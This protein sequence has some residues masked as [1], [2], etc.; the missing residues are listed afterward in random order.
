MNG[1]LVDKNGGRLAAVVTLLPVSLT[2]RCLS[3]FCFNVLHD[4]VEYFKHSKFYKESFVYN[5][6]KLLIFFIP[7]SLSTTCK[8]LVTF[9]Y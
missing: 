2:C 1:F 8:A 4:H 6:N 9:C 3:K 7:Q 5:K